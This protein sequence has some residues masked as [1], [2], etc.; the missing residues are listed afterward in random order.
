[1]DSWRILRHAADPEAA[2]TNDLA[3]IELQRAGQAF[4]QGRLAG[5]VLAHQ[6]RARV[7]EQERDVLED[8][9]RAV[10]ERGVLHAE[11]GLTRRHCRSCDVEARF[12]RPL[13]RPSSYSAASFLGASVVGTGLKLR[14]GALKPQLVPSVTLTSSSH[15]S[16]YLPAAR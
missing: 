8:T 2:R 6:C 5:A 16:A 13:E 7:V 1:E 12:W 3:G 15:G 14:V 4:Q 11:H 9:A 10:I